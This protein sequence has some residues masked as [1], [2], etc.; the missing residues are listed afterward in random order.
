MGSQMFMNLIKV[1]AEVMN[2]YNR[3]QNNIPNPGHYNPNMYNPNMYN[4]MHN[5]NMYNQ[6]LDYNI[7]YTGNNYRDV[8]NYY[9]N[10]IKSF[11]YKQI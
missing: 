5:Y 2:I 3:P 11:L 10:K 1:L 6:N 7:P 8:N 4:G 9:K